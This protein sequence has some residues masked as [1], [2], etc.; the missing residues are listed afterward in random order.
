[1]DE[2]LISILE[3]YMKSI[4]LLKLLILEIKSGNLAA[5]RCSLKKKGVL[6]LYKKTKTKSNRKDKTRKQPIFLNNVN[7]KDF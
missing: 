5:Q 6:E 1:M 7:S 4:K 2:K 3:H